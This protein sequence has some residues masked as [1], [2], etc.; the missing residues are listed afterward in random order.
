MKLGLVLSGGGIRGV[1]HIGVIKALEEMGISPTHIAGSS[2]GAIVGAL[3]AYGYD[4]K[5]ILKFFKEI[6]ILD[7]KKYARKKPGFIDSEKFYNEFNSYFKVDNFNVLKKTLL[8]TAT[9][10]L[11]GKLT[12]FNQGELIRPVIASASFPGVFSP[13][14]IEDSYYIDG[15]ALDNFPV[16]LLSKQ[17]DYIIGV[18]VNG[19]KHLQ[20]EDLKHSYNVVERAFKIKSVE[21]DMQKF[22]TCN[23]LIAPSNLSQYGTFDKKNLKEIFELGYTEAHN[24]LKSSSLIKLINPPNK[25]IKMN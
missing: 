16:D 15:G 19:I 8:V 22:S 7:I 18:Y 20:I 3:Y 23:L 12:V 21:E 9:D 10:I 1:A 14:K 6:Q 4:W 25:K 11:R 2:S 17:C 24:S 5:T 13:I